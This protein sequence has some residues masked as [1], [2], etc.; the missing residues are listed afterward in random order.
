MVDGPGILAASTSGGEAGHHHIGGLIKCL[1]LQRGGIHDISEAHLGSRE[2]S[3]HLVACLATSEA[4]AF[5][6]ERHDV[7]APLH[8][9][10]HHET[11]D[12]SSGSEHHHPNLLRRAVSEVVAQRHDDRVGGQQR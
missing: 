1:G 5:P 4:A 7:V 6:R 11:T 3:D 8:Q 2:V 9:F 12:V 10:P